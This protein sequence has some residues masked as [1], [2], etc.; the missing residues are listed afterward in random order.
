MNAVEFRPVAAAIQARWFAF[1]IPPSALAQYVVDLADLRS[2]DVAAAVDSLGDRERPPS[3]GQI[4]RRV[5]ELQLDAPAWPEARAALARWRGRVD[6]RVDA[7]A[8]W[9]CPAGVCDGSGFAIEDRDA[10][11]CVCRPARQSQLRGLSDLPVLVAEF[12]G[13]DGQVSN[14][15][16]DKLLEGDT[17]LDAQVRGRWEQFVRRIVDSRVFAALPASDSMPR[18]EAARA[19]QL[20]REER[21]GG[22]RRMVPVALLERGA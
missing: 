1:E 17:Q 22:L 2:G 5:V 12:V 9:V 13:V 18:I 3:P 6:D 19:E 21:G 20:Q 11:N 14:G 4:R 15:E 7:I 8:G 10:R 16:L